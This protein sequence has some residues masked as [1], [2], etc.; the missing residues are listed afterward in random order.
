VTTK[1]PNVNG[2]ARLAL[3]APQGVVEPLRPRPRGLQAGEDVGGEPNA[4]VLDH[5]GGDL[6]G[7]HLGLVDGR[8]VPEQGDDLPGL[9]RGRGRP[10]RRH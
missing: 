6:A 4:S 10:Q 1:L 3:D 5:S 7:P 2:A 8:V 9:P